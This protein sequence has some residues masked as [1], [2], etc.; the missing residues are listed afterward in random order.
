[1]HAAVT[2]PCQPRS[3]AEA[4]RFV[5]RS[6]AASG[7][8]PGV[9]E[10]AE[11]LASELVTNAVLHARTPFHVSVAVADGVAR[12]GVTDRSTRL[13]ARRRHSVESATGRGLVLVEQLAA[14]WG[15]DARPDDKTVWFEVR[16]GVGDV[17]PDL[18]A[19]LAR[20]AQFA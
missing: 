8:P 10:T 19:F 17:E 18:D 20:E 3:V 6:L 5:S 15:I 2:L 16:P 13:L 9:V 14:S 12:V 7:S 4:R 11:L 1:M